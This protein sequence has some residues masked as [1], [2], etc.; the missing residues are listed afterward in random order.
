MRFLWPTKLNPEP[1]VL[2]RFGR[3]LHWIGTLLFIL[4]IIAT[5]IGAGTGVYQLATNAVSYYGTPYGPTTL[6]SSATGFV[7]GFALYLVSRAL[8]YILSGE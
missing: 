7:L 3:V 2:T 4:V 1:G 6:I 8:R 5:V